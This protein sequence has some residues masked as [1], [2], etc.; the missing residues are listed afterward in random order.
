MGLFGFLKKKHQSE[1]FQTV[2]SHILGDSPETAVPQP[3]PELSRA[4]PISQPP[5]ELPRADPMTM[6]K[7][8]SPGYGRFGTPK[9]PPLREDI[10]TFEPFAPPQEEPKMGNTYDI[11][12]RLE[13]IESQLG[14]IRSQTETIN[15][16]LKN[17]EM[18]LSRRY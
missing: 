6:E 5:P 14:A 13:V 3:P 1:D 10:E 12:Q 11:S 18:K 9:P 7:P 2:R 4:D 15:E 17:L 16:R 8:P